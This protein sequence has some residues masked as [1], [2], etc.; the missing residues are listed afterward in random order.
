MRQQEGD[1]L[2]G[3]AV[4]RG[5][6]RGGV[7]QEA[8]ER[9]ALAAVEAREQRQVV[10]A[11]EGRVRLA[12]G[13]DRVRVGQQQALHRW[14]SR[15]S[16]LGLLVLAGQHRLAQQRDQRV[17]LGRVPGAVLVQRLPGPVVHARGQPHE[18]LGRVVQR[19]GDL[20]AQQGRHQRQALAFRHA[21]EVG[22]AQRARLGGELAQLAVRHAGERLRPP[23]PA[24]AARRGGPGARACAA[25]SGA[26]GRPWPGPSRTGWR[27]RAP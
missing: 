27:R 25:G 14:Q 26:A 19:L 18:H 1:G 22:G 24:R 17:G 8:Q 21:A 13:Q 2:L 23:R 20:A 3:G 16:G 5:G 7:G 9:R 12:L 11:R 10:V 6:D 4:L 15:A